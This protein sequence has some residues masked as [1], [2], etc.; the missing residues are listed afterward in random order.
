M[1][2]LALT[3]AMA[4]YDRTAG[5]RDGSV[6]ASGVGLRYVV[7]PPSETFWRMLKFDEF[8][9]AE[10]SLSSLLIARQQGR[11]WTAIPVFPFR[12]FFHTYVFVRA[13]S[14]IRH[15]SGLAGARFGLPEYQM[16]AAVWVRGVLQQDFG[17]APSAIRWYVERTPSMSHGGQTGF[18]APAGVSIERVPEGETLLSLLER[19]RLD[20]VMPSPYGGMTSRL[21][22]T[23]VAQ[24]RRSPHV[25]L[26]FEDPLAESVRSFRAEGFSHVNHTVVVQTRVLEEHPWVALNLFNAFAQAKAQCYGRLDYLLRSSVMAAFAVLDAQR[27]TFGDDP[28]PYGLSANRTALETLAQYSFEQGLTSKRADI[29]ALFAPTTRDL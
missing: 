8:D 22:K 4:D 29:D 20:A 13:D 16:T 17:V 18:T 1:S 9:A 6:T 7:S 23:Y 24:L 21:N 3:L 26:L 25:R 15:P 11:A 12:A 10:M 2:D 28:F 14:R 19:G 27:R 5:L